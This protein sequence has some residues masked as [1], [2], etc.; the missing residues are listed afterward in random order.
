MKNLDNFILQIDNFFDKQHCINFIDLYK[1]VE[2][3]GMVETRNRPNHELEDSQVFL[4]EAVNFPMSYDMMDNIGNH[5]KFFIKKFWDDAYSV[6]TEKYS[7]LNDFASHNIYALK[8][9]KSLPGQGYHGWHAEID[10]TVHTPR[11]LSF[12]LYLNDVKEGG[13]TEFLYY[14]KRIKPEQGKLVMFPGSFTHTHRGNQPL[15]GEKYIL[16]GWVFFNS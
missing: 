15:S 3:C 1:H 8:I 9:Q 2:N 6:Y 11:L 16:T 4:H 10:N 12:I 5:S 14:P 7:I 13:E